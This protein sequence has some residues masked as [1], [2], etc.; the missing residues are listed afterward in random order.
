M[1]IDE[2]SQGGTFTMGLFDAILGLFKSGT[3]TA[4]ATGDK[5][6][7]GDE[8]DKGDKGDKGE[9][10]D[11]GVDATG[12]QL[13]KLPV[14]FVLITSEANVNFIVGV[15]TAMEDVKAFWEPLGI[16]VQPRISGMVADESI[17]TFDF[18]QPE[19]TNGHF[20][21]PFGGTLTMYIGHTSTKVA[22]DVYGEARSDG[23]AVVA[24]APDTTVTMAEITNHELGHL[25]DL[26]H[27]EGTF[28]REILDTHIDTVTTAQ[29]E[30]LKTTA[31]AFGGF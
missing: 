10:G 9:K 8:G 3:G 1:G 20:F 27:E 14:N 25:L 21:G 19:L 11:P 28:M 7:K 5:G 31:Y 17:L 18:T 22:D 16:D 4:G 15:R 26:S 12:A 6:D 23:I 13:I 29:L 2:Y 30:T 24:G